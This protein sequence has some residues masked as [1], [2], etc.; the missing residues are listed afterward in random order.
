VP[1]TDRYW[2]V[3]LTWANG[4]IMM[5]SVTGAT[6]PAA[7]GE[8]FHRLMFEGPPGWVWRL[9]DIRL[10]EQVHHVKP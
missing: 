8:V 6:R 7:A 2:R 5:F 10:S 3:T 4:A 9:Q 1:S